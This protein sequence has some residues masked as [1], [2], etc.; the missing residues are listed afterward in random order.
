MSSNSLK[1]LLIFNVL[2]GFK[3]SVQY[4]L[5]I[6]SLSNLP[7]ASIGL[8]ILKFNSGESNINSLVKVFKSIVYII[9]TELR[10]AGIKS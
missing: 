6:V 1:S 3:L 2:T 10:P 5:W 7:I 4:I 8:F 9:P